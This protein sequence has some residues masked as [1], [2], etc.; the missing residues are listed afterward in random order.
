[1][2]TGF[3]E[4]D[5]HAFY[6]DVWPRI[7]NY[8][9]AVESNWEAARKGERPILIKWGY[10]DKAGDKVIVAISKADSG[11]ERHWVDEGL[12]KKVV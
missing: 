12:M 4:I 7:K 10:K 1:M 8:V 11:G 9:D 5:R 3:V 6:G 2:T